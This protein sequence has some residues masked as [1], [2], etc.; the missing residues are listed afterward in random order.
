MPI[1]VCIVQ[2]PEGLSVEG[3]GTNK[4]AARANACQKA[5]KVYDNQKTID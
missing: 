3:R 5:M 1:A 4:K 2:L